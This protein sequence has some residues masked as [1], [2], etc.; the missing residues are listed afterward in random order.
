MRT[1]VVIDLCNI[2]GPTR[3][4]VNLDSVLK[5]VK[6]HYRTADIRVYNKFNSM[7]EVAA[8]RQAFPELELSF[9]V[10]R[11]AFKGDPDLDVAITVD[12]MRLYKEYD[13]IVLCTGDADFVPLLDHLEREGVHTEIMANKKSFA[14][15]LS[16]H[17]KAVIFIPEEVLFHE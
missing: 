14:L 8:F 6:R 10:T 13:R 4:P 9:V 12:V 5:F 3:K 15:S 11:S 17:A 2:Q 16:K 7:R 1:L